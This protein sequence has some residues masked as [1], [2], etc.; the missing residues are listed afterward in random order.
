MT[1]PSRVFDSVFFFREALEHLL[2]SLS[3]QE[4]GQ[5]EQGSPTVYG[6]IPVLPL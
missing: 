5:A 2:H 6:A 1:E 3:S 4:F